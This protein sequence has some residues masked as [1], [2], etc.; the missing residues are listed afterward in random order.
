MDLENLV[1]LI[2]AM[3]VGVYMLYCLLRPQD[4]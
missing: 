2:V 1:A 4:F 3:A